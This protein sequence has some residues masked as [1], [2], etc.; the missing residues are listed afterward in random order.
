M[1]KSLCSYN[2]NTP[3]ALGIAYSTG[4][5]YTPK[6]TMLFLRSFAGV[7]SGMASNPFEI[8]TVNPKKIKRVCGPPRL[9]GILL[10]GE[11]DIKCSPIETIGSI[12]PINEYFRNENPDPLYE[13]YVNHLNESGSAWGHTTEDEFDERLVELEQL[14][15]SINKNGFLS[16]EE[17]KDRGHSPEQNNNE[18]IPTKLNEVSVN[19]SRSGEPLY[20]GFG[21][22]RLAIA[23]LLDVE[24]IP[25][26]VATRHSEFGNRVPFQ[27][28]NRQAD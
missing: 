4:L 25:V 1:M 17:L 27:T 20:A 24:K 23:R 19:I 8:Y 11:W 15:D 2:K 12:E 26:I 7:H 14:Y 6:L 3:L 21:S 16:Q 9:Y 28:Y 5:R 18:P 22:H 13:L 10:G